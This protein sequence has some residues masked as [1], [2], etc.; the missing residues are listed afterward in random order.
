MDVIFDE[1][2]FNISMV[3]ERNHRMNL[4]EVFYRGSSPVRL[5]GDLSPC[6]E[7]RAGE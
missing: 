5:L 7:C 6:V 2:D 4:P 1:I 3:C